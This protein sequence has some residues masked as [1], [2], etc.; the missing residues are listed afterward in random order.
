MNS[1]LETECDNRIYYSGA[2]FTEG[3][4]EYYPIPLPQYNFSGGR[5]IQNPG[6]PAF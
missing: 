6:Y 4:D 2:K 5:Y 1:Y 3:K